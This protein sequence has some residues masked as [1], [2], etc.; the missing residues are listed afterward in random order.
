MDLNAEPRVLHQLRNHL[1]II[2]GFCDLLLADIPESDRK[3]ADIREMRTAGQAALD[4]LPDV[5]ERMQSS[6]D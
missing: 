4:L 1:A 2:V 3:H 5:A 6:D